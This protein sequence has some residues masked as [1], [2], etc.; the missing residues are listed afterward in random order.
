MVSEWLHIEVNQGKR[1]CDPNL[2]CSEVKTE[3]AVVATGR[4]AAYRLGLPDVCA[5]VVITRIGVAGG[6][7]RGWGPSKDLGFLP[8]RSR[9]PIL[10]KPPQ[11]YKQR[12]SYLVLARSAPR[13]LRLQPWPFAKRAMKAR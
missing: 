13:I 1:T 4:G 10:S 8:Q 6:G 5:A 11:D 12:L 3:S 7:W 2:P 9:H